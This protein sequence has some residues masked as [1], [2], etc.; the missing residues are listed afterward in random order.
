MVTE[1]CG[2]PRVRMKYSTSCLTGASFFGIFTKSE[3][4]KMMEPLVL[5]GLSVKVRHASVS[6]SIRHCPRIARYKLNAWRK[7][8]P[9]MGDGIFVTINV[10]DSGR[11]K[12][13]FRERRLFP[14]VGIRERLIACLKCVVK[15]FCH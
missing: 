11:L 5:I 1:D 10:Q 7:S 15:N 14:Y 3:F 6:A 13:R 4:R 2:R 12:P 9:I 8:A